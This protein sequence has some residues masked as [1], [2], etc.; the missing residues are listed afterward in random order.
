MASNRDGS[1]LAATATEATD[2]DATPL[3]RRLWLRRPLPVGQKA[4]GDSPVPAAEKGAHDGDHHGEE[5]DDDDDH[6][7]HPVGSRKWLAHQLHRESFHHTIIG[8]VLFDLILVF[9]DLIL[10]IMTSCSPKTDEGSGEGSSGS[11]NATEATATDAASNETATAATSALLTCSPNIRESA[12]LSMGEDALYWMSVALLTIFAIEVVLNVYARGLR[13]LKSVVMAIDAMVVYASLTHTIEMR[14]HNI[15]KAVRS[16]NKAISSACATAAEAFAGGKRE[17]LTGMRD[18]GADL[19]KKGDA[20][21]AFRPTAEEA[22]ASGRMV[23]LAGEF[24]NR[25]E[26]ALRDMEETMVRENRQQLEATLK[27]TDA[28][29]EEEDEEEDEEPERDSS[30]DDNGDKDGPHGRG[31]HAEGQNVGE[32]GEDL[33]NEALPEDAEERAEADDAARDDWMLASEADEARKE[34]RELKAAHPREFAAAAA[35]E[36]HHHH[37]LEK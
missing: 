24:M 34:L 23:V 2:A 27:N 7:H 14:G 28:E 10:A 18:A 8:L 19:K 9:L 31:R 5:D 25:L 33:S 13:H 36:E 16:S 21:S 29:G 11:G 32:D 3:R 4:G 6:A 20:V 22:R 30:G 37:G 35:A 15:I 17:F 12:A 26:A 1:A